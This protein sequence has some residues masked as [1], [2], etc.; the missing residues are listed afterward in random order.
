MQGHPLLRAAAK[1]VREAKYRHK[2]TFAR[3]R[4]S[5]P[6]TETDRRYAGA[7]TAVVLYRLAEVPTRRGPLTSAQLTT[8]AQQ[9]EA[10][11]DS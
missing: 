10:E 7:A 3:G 11:A 6:P 1:A 4:R 2:G 8:L 9:I 5:I